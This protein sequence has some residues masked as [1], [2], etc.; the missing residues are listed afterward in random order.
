MKFVLIYAEPCMNRAFTYLANVLFIMWKI[1]KIWTMVQ[2][3]SELI[4]QSMYDLK[5]RAYIEHSWIILYIYVRES[6][7]CI[8]GVKNSYKD[9]R[10]P[11]VNWK[12]FWDKTN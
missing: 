5:L 10:K 1:P 2:T 7:S 12:I 3:N 6:W 11:E 8:Y 4:N 9:C